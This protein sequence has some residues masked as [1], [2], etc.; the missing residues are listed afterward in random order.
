MTDT[1]ITLIK[2]TYTQNNFGVD[3]PTETSRTVLCSLKSVARSD[4]Y[5]AGQAGFAL[6]HVFV[7]DP[8]N[9]DGEQI[10]EFNGKRYEIT[11]VYQASANSLEIYAGHKVGVFQ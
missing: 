3:I 6:D 11:R 7:T 9:Y 8:I 5:A 1:A 10:A 4:F 2:E